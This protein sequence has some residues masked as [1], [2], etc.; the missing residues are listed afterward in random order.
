M[1][2]WQGQK[3]SDIQAQLQAMNLNLQVQVNGPQ[4]DKARIV[5][6][7]TP[8]GAALNEGQVIQFQTMSFGPNG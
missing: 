5:N 2:N 3:L 6:S 7:D 8:P 1:P 4:D